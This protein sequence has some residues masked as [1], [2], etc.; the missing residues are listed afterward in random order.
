LNNLPLSFPAGPWQTLLAKAYSLLDAVADDNPGMNLPE[1]TLGGGTVL[2]FYYAHRLSKDIDI[3]VAEAQFLGYLNPRLGGP[4]E[5]LTTEY[6]EGAEFLK[7]NF[8]EGEIDFVASTP[9]TQQ[10]F[11]HYVV[12]GRPIKLQ[13]PVEIVA[14][15]IWHRGNTATARDLLDLALVIDKHYDEILNNK[16]IFQKNIIEFTKQCEHRK[17]FLLPIFNAIEKINFSLT[18]E[19]CLGLV[20]KLKDDLASTL[21]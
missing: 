11:N 3:F 20:N 17:Q 14:K 19:Q 9:L 15:K 6:A 1:W 18:Y 4:A 16:E 7:L 13:T 10:P 21:N 12:L 5:A 8:A 2:M